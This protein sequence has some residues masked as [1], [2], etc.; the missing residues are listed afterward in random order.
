MHASF[1]VH[2]SKKGCNRAVLVIYRGV[3]S[4]VNLADRK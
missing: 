2:R 3:R 1:P 4:R